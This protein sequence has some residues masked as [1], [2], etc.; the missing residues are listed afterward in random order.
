MRPFTQLIAGDLN[1]H[2]PRFPREAAGFPEDGSPH[3]VS[4]ARR[5]YSKF[6]DFGHSRGV[7]EL[8]LE[9][10][11][12]HPQH[13]PVFLDEQAVK[14]GIIHF[15]VINSAESLRGELVPSISQIRS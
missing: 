11:I 5:T 1:L 4:A 6:H 2:A 3:A 10:Q 7:M 14:P 13:F 15:F 8:F 9:T 12:Q